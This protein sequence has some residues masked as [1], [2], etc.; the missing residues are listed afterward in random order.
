MTSTRPFLDVRMACVFVLG[1]LVAACGGPDVAQTGVQ[2]PEAA[3]PP[4]GSGAMRSS[5]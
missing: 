4:E 2:A 3:A 1:A 5:A